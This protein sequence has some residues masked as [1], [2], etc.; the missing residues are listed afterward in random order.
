[1]QWYA[2]CLACHLSAAH[3]IL[4]ALLEGLSSLLFEQGK[5]IKDRKEG[6]ITRCKG[7]LFFVE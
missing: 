4:K 7:S 6:K 5:R 1:M 2:F 3:K